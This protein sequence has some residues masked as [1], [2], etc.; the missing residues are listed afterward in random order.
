[1]TYGEQ[2]GRSGGRRVL[3]LLLAAVVG[4]VLVLVVRAVVTG[5]DWARTAMPAVAAAPTAA[6]SAPAACRCR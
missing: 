1:M 5:G 6:A 2:T 4:L 3:P